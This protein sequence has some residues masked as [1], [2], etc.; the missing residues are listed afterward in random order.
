MAQMQPGGEPS[1]MGKQQSL[2]E[3]EPRVPDLRQTDSGLNQQERYGDQNNAG[4][5]LYRPGSPVKYSGEYVVV[6]QQGNKQDREMITLDE[7]ETFPLLEDTQYCYALNE[8]GY[9]AGTS[10]EEEDWGNTPSYN[11]NNYDAADELTLSNAGSATS[12]EA[13]A[14]QLQTKLRDMDE[15]VDDIN[16]PE[17]NKFYGEAVVVD[18]PP[19]EDLTMERE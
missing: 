14:E 9:E 18:E 3:E 1:R 19:A 12:T 5:E 6:D 16:D 2:L 13:E 17:I 4:T 11:L 15:P 7:G 10:V 8:T